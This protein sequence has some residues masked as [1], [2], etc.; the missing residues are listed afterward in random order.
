MEGCAG[1][2]KEKFGHALSKTVDHTP[3]VAS[4]SRLLL[5]HAVKRPQSAD[6]IDRVD[7][8]DVRPGNSSASMPSARGRSDR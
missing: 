7:P 2:K 3:F 1:S 6:E 4:M 8:D 5:R